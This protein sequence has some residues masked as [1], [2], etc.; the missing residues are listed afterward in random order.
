MLVVQDASYSRLGNNTGSSNLL[1]RRKTKLAVE[2]K[3]ISNSSKQHFAQWRVHIHVEFALD[4]V[5]SKS[6]KVLLVVSKD[7]NVVFLL[8]LVP[9][10][11][12]AQPLGA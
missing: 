12:Q 6:S 9:Q 10:L 4:V 5:G 3:E 2:S 1:S 7:T 8:L 11:T